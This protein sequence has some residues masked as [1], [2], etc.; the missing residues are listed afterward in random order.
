YLAILRDSFREALLSR[1][2]PFLLGFFTLVLLVLAP[3][4]LEED[5]PWRLSFEEI[6]DQRLWLVK[7]RV[8]SQEEGDNPGKRVLERL[9]A[10]AKAHLGLGGEAAAAEAEGASGAFVLTSSINRDVLPDR[11]LY[12]AAAWE[13]VR[14]DD[15][16]RALL[17]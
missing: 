8:E 15:E 14:L 13:D 3:I 17:E 5:V 16:A 12:D 6:A 10:E 11:T 4:G 2:L 9:S 7:L 1:T